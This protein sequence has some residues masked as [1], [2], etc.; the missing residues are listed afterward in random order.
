MR[1]RYRRVDLFAGSWLLPD[2]A[3][4][5]T[6]GDRLRGLHRTDADAVLIRTGSIHTLTTRR[7]I[8][9]SA[10]DRSGIVLRSTVL[11]PRSLFSDRGAAWILEYDHAAVPP[12]MGAVLR[13]VASSGYAGSTRRLRHSDRQPR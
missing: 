13:V 2:V 3:V 6:F 10:I 9:L 8:G 11:R 4:A 1:P 7:P 12:P 5:V